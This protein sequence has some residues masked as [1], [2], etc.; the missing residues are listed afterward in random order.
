MSAVM[1]KVGGIELIHIFPVSGIA[2][3]LCDNI[4]ETISITTDN[5][6]VME[7]LRK[8]ETEFAAINDGEV[9][10]KLKATDP[11]LTLKL[12]ALL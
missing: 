6:T 1:I 7:I 12:T 3:I 4:S 9:L 10:W 11:T 5:A 8:D 2:H